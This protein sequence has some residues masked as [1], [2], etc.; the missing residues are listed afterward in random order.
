MGAERES[1]EKILNAPVR[2]IKS[3]RLLELTVT[4]NANSLAMS[5]ELLEALGRTISRIFP[6]REVSR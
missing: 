6:K 1:K 4:A 3:P 5:F 2:A